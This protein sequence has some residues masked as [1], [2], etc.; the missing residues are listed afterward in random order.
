[1][2]QSEAIDRIRQVAI[3]LTSVDAPTARRILGQLPAAQGRLVRQ[4]MAN[5]GSVSPAERQTAM[6]S[7]MLLTQSKPP[8]QTRHK[9]E[10]PSSSVTSPAEALLSKAESMIDR[11]EISEDAIALTATSPTKNLDTSS[12]REFQPVGGDSQNPFLPPTWAS[13]WQQWKG[14][15]LARL[16]MN[17]RPNVIAALI[18]QCPNE[19]ATSILEALPS[20]TASSVLASLPQ[21]ASTDPYLLQEIYDVLHTRLIDFQRQSSPTNAGMSKL[22]SLLGSLSNEHRQ[23][24][25][26]AFGQSQ[27]LLAHSLGIE[28]ERNSLQASS[29]TTNTYNG[30][31]TSPPVKA[32]ETDR[33]FESNAPVAKSSNNTDTLYDSNDDIADFIVPFTSA[34]NNAPETNEPEASDLAFENLIHFS[35]EELAIVLRSLD[36]DT[37]LLAISGGSEAIQKRIE[38]LIAPEEVKRLRKRLRSLRSRASDHKAAAQKKIV[39]MANQ[40]LQQGHIAGYASVAFVAA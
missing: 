22:Q 2:S 17:E 16:L 3:V 38:S 9:P 24:I 6:K 25:Q 27:P 23:R 19:L 40:L 34:E 28:I 21:L 18:L 5:L 15:D 37:I 14:D 31:R 26:E 32:I 4:R 35:S 29:T 7:F 8:A 1:M 13:A 36:P 39:R 30:I 10:S 12:F 20:Q 33:A 11:F